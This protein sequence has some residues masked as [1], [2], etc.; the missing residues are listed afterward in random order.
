MKK[1]AIANLGVAFAMLFML[2][3]AE[4]FRARQILGV[5]IG[6]Y[7][8]LLDVAVLIVSIVTGVLLWKSS[9]KT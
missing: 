1:L 9:R 3:V 2:V 7:W 4:G 5:F 8:V 6:I